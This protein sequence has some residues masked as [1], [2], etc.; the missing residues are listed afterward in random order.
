MGAR[1]PKPKPAKIR[2]LSG[3]SHHKKE[4]PPVTLEID[5]APQSDYEYIPNAKELWD[6]LSMAGIVK[7][8]DRLAY[9][10]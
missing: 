3:P 7:A 10:R 1:G 6:S 9:L 4:P 8:S 2:E 5:N